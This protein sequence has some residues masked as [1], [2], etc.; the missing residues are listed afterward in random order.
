MSGPVANDPAG[1]G[2]PVNGPAA[3]GARPA[4]AA[5]PATPRYGRSAGGGTATNSGLGDIV[6]AVG[7][8]VVGGG[9]D[10][11]FQLDVVGKVKF[12]TADAN[13][14][15]G[16]GKND[17][18]GQL[19]ATY[20]VT[21]ETSLLG[22]AGYRI[23]GK[24]AG[25]TVNNVFFGSAGLDHATSNVTSAGVLFDYV[26]KITFYGY[27]QK[28]GMVYVSHK[29]S[30]TLKAM[31][32]LLKGFSNGSPDRGIGATLTGYFRPPGPRARRHCGAGPHLGAGPWDTST[33]PCGRSHLA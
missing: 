28:D 22:T 18:S 30:P 31:G 12:G 14:G 19:D 4:P 1:N 29:L 16:T 9:N 26:Q 33:M 17:Y 23:I 5:T 8:T 20:W 11:V 27:E 2:T 25:I 6:A 32:Y 21:D 7:R 15:L 10:D 24:P 13:A 3:A